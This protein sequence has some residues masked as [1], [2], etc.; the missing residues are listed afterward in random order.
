MSTK[1][2]KVP[3]DIYI[4]V[5][6]YIVVL[7]IAYIIESLEWGGFSPSDPWDGNL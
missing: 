3:S 2:A 7:Y 6:D 4:H 1:H 5:V